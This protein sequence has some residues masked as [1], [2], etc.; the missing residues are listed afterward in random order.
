MADMPKPPRGRVAELTDE[1]LEGFELS[2][3][4]CRGCSGYGNCGYKTY[5]L[6]HGKVAAICNLRKRQ[7]ICKRD[8][9]P[10]EE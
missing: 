2:Q 1:D 3:M 5:H 6:Y 7:L 4:T 9:I 8:G 10:F